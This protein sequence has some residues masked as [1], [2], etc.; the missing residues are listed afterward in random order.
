MNRYV[1]VCDDPLRIPA[2]MKFEH[3]SLSNL[4]SPPLDTQFYFIDATDPTYAL[5]AAR[6][7]RRHLLPTVYLRPIVFIS[8]GDPFPEEIS[9]MVDVTVESSA[10][11]SY[12]VERL[13]DSFGRCLGRIEALPDKGGAYDHNSALRILRFM[14]VRDIPLK[15]ARTS[16]SR[17]GFE[18]PLISLLFESQDGE[19]FKVL[20]FMSGQ[21]L[22]AG[23]FFDKAYFCSNC[24]CAFLNFRE[25]CPHCDS[26]NLAVDDLVHHYQCANISPLAKYKL[27][28]GQLQCP[29]CN[30]MLKHIGVDYD[31]PSLIYNCNKCGYSFQDPHIS[32]I[33]YNCGKHSP[34][35]EVHHRSIYDYTLTSLGK[36]AALYGLDALFK[37]ILDKSLNTIPLDVF[38]IMLS[39]ERERIRRYKKSVSS[40]AAFYIKDLDRLQVSLGDKAEDIFRE[41]SSIVKGVLRSSDI[42]SSVNNS[43]FFFLLVETPL[44]GAHT[45]M[46]RLREK[47]IELFSANIDLQVQISTASA[48]VTE[49]E[50]VE[51]LARLLTDNVTDK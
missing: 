39:L 2:G 30:R 38:K 22:L 12:A 31:K 17:Y 15:C 8:P 47:I 34:P 45:A 33:C 35:D 6:F 9:R 28:N 26:A 32:T 51:A 20:E 42:T 49:G 7:I 13:F 40:L 5:A 50:N 11:N 3:L 19:I 25:E 36:S 37:S 4:T 41:L 10:L 18:Y 43:L 27:P 29:K 14:Y 24:S 48:P 44:E 46:T 23:S 21:G 16:A 1:C